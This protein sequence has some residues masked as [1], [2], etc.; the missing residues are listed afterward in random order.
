M[1]SNTFAGIAL[2]SVPGFIGAQLVG[3]ALAAAVIRMLYPRIGAAD[4]A[5][6]IVPHPS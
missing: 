3:A 4:A 1:F 6:V 5:T 2:A